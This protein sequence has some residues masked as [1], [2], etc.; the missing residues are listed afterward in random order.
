[1][2][3]FYMCQKQG[4]HYIWTMA[5]FERTLSSV[6]LLQE[7]YEDA[8]L[9]ICSCLYLDKTQEYKK[10]MAAPYKQNAL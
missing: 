7:K 8:Y 10:K 3:V 2:W 6:F 1:M 5:W 9:C 4:L